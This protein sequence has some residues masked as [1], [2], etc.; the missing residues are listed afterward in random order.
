M[1]PAIPNCPTNQQIARSARRCCAGRYQN[2]KNLWITRSSRRRFEC[3][4]RAD[5]RKPGR[6]R[7]VQKAAG[8]GR[9]R[10]A[11]SG[12]FR[13]AFGPL[14]GRELAWGIGSRRLF[15]TGQAGLPAAALGCRASLSCIW[16]QV[17][18]YPI[19]KP[20]AAPVDTAL[21]AINSGEICG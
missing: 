3:G 12:F 7:G 20:P 18:A 19:G 11:V 5:F 1:G 9:Q 8:G 21:G 17:F 15:G 13:L 6:L 4:K 16:I 10:L 14:A 2:R